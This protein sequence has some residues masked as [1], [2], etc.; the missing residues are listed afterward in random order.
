MQEWMGGVIVF[1]PRF[2]Y[3]DTGDTIFQEVFYI[4]YGII[5]HEGNSMFFAEYRFCYFI[6]F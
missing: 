6:L 4:V 1:I 3:E 2:F 5:N